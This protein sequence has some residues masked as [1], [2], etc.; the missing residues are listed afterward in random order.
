MKTDVVASLPNLTLA[1][2][3]ITTGTNASY[4]N[5]FRPVYEAF[6]L[7]HR[8]SLRDLRSRL[9][10]KA[11]TPSPPLRLYYPKPSGLH[12]PFTLL[13]VEDQIVLQAFA[14]LFANKIRIKRAPLEG[15]SLFSGLLSPR[16]SPFL[17]ADWR[18]GY[19]A[20]LQ[21]LLA[22]AS[23]GNVWLATFDLSAFYDTIS[24]NVLT[25]TIAPRSANRELPTLFLH[26]LKQ[27]SSQDVSTQHSHG[28]PQGPI[29]STL[30][31]EAV[32]LPIDRVMASQC[33]YTR[34]VDDIRILAKSET[35]IRRAVVQLDTLCR[36]I[37]L[38]PHGDKTSIFRLKRALDIK[39]H[40]PP[41]EQYATAAGRGGLAPK[42]A[43]RLLRESLDPQRRRVAD[44]TTF[45]YTMFRAAP[46]PAI[47]KAALRLWQSHPEQTDAITAY[48]EAYAHSNEVVNYCI[49]SIRAGSPYAAVRA[50]HWRLLARLATPQQVRRLCTLAIQDVKDQRQRPA[51]AIGALTFLCSAQHHGL[52]AYGRYLRWASHV[53]IQA[54]VAPHLPLTPSTATTVLSLMS[55]SVPDPGLALTRSFLVGG[56]SPVSFGASPG[57]LNPVLRLAYEAAGLLPPSALRPRDAISILL[58]ARYRISQW[59]SWRAFLGSD[60]AHIHQILV[61]AEAYF[62]SQ[63]STWLVYQDSFNDAVIRVFLDFLSVL[64]HPA[65]IPT[66]APSGSL[67]DV[68]GL[69][70]DHRFSSR[71]P[72]IAY[73][74]RDVHTRRNRVPGSHPYDKKTGA[75]AVPLSRLEQRA[76][77]R[78][79]TQAYASIIAECTRLGI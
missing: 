41:L 64:G 53:L 58:S 18:Q 25:A 68:G 43:L 30:L 79:L 59:Q 12:R 62:L 6:E 40:V 57:R 60:Y 73:N 27:W 11:Y 63:P 26:C 65:A 39:D 55:R 75:K 28:I 35:E 4:K 23:S 20:L 2:R 50:E 3:R 34:Y 48:L 44:K 51:A 13:A 46:S 72:A 78:Q 45:R 52:G 29:A 69:L 5:N 9:K 77:V 47:L 37:G 71:L 10:G 7:A 21:R 14:N 70:A 16:R 38:V 17:F 42:R 76:F 1:W 33:K 36:D 8:E 56:A 61:T 32:M 67:I 22:W 31:A 54:I 49:A 24:H 66:I 15:R 74:L 19:D